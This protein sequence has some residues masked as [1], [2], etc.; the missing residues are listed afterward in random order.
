MF[1]EE[2]IRATPLNY[3]QK[4]IFQTMN[5]VNDVNKTQVGDHY[6]PTILKCMWQ[7]RGSV[8]FPQRRERTGFRSGD[9]T[10]VRARLLRL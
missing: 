2:I 10:R 7:F 4:I 5:Q 6:M 3:K 1:I 9:E 8:V